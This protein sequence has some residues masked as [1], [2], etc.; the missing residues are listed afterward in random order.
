MEP[1]DAIDLGPYPALESKLKIR[2]GAYEDIAPFGAFCLDE[3]R[4]AELAP[5]PY[6]ALFKQQ[7]AE[8]LSSPD[9]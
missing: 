3:H 5:N 8:A 7:L 4:S 9:H 6:Y 2:D 1:I